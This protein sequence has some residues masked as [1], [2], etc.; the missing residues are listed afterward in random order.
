MNINASPDVFVTS[1]FPPDAGGIQRVTERLA[2]SGTQA[3]HDIFVIAPAADGD[4]A[5]DAAAPFRVVRYP[6][7]GGIAK[8]LTIAYTVW[9][10]TRTIRP[11]SI[12]AMTWNPPALALAPLRLL[13]RAP[14]T[15]LA[16]GTE[17]AT[18]NGILRRALLRLALR[19]ADVVANSG[20]TAGLLRERGITRVRIVHPGADRVDLGD[21]PRAEAP[22]ILCAGRLIARKGYDRV[23]AAMPAV[24]ARI[25]GAQL[26]VVGDGP[27]RVRLEA[28][29]AES[30]AA[31]H[32]RFLGR[33]N[34]AV[35][36]HAY[37]SA[38][39]FAMPNRRDGNDVEGFG[40]VFLEAALHGLP[41]IGGR[42]SGADD[43]I[44]D[45]V[46]GRLVD[47]ESIGAVTDALIDVLGDRERAL[48]MGAL[49][50]TRAQTTF[51]WERY[52]EQLLDNPTPAAT[53][54]GV[55]T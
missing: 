33:V 12:V 10:A 31:E 3:G 2:A 11:R 50:R 16:H 22:T 36:A 6:R 47:G 49:A 1:D 26:I 32:I 14:L 19:G 35:L 27:D 52:A 28:L 44:V 9:R 18:Q 4:A 8:Y 42:D 54:I 48:R 20:F 34:D 41:A 21:A 46:T 23:I 55:A 17:I 30:S 40:I 53:A 25:P 13:L 7:R 37:A 5:Y 51:T 15:V 45:G 38:W 39:C 29:A 24:V 43:A